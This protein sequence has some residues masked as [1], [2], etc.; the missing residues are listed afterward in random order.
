VPLGA[1]LVLSWRGEVSL[2]GI[3]IIIVVTSPSWRA[4]LGLAQPV[5][6]PYA[7]GFVGLTLTRL[8]AITQ[9][10]RRERLALRAS[11]IGFELL[12]CC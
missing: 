9:T 1:V 7:S 12:I 5:D 4:Q 8:G 3:L 6:R 2:G 11:P 10:A